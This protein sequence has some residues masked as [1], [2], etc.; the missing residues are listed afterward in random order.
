MQVLQEKK[1]LEGEQNIA[2]QNTKIQHLMAENNRLKQL[3]LI[4][5]AARRNL[6]STDNELD[7]RWM[8]TAGLPACPL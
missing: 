1:V 7:Y 6:P 2:K 8:V 5:D 4:D 3:C